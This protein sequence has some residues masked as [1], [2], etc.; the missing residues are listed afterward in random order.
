SG[1]YHISVTIDDRPTDTSPADADTD[2]SATA[3]VSDAPILA[4][5]TVN[6]T[7]TEGKDVTV[8]AEFN[9]EG[10]RAGAIDSHLSATVD[11]GD[12]TSSAGTIGAPTNEGECECN[13]MVSATRHDYDARA[14][15]FTVS[16]T[17]KDDGGSTKTS[18]LT[19]TIAD[20]ALTAGT[21]KSF[22]STAT[23]AS[24][25]VVASFSDA[26]GAQAAAAD[27]TATIK[28]GDNTTSSGT[29]TKTATGAFNVSGTHT[30]ATAGTKS[31]TVTVTDEE[32]QTA[33]MT[34]TANVGAAPV[35]L[36][37]TGQPDGNSGLPVLPAAL[38]LLGLVGVSAGLLRM[39]LA[40][41]SS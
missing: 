28:W 34:A 22:T 30:Y 14:T 15:K 21:A 8:K 36:P 9:D 17:L 31:V 24:S 29:V 12:G 32:G 2:Q 10:S 1:T 37:A 25:N 4:G 13:V 35:S 38:I 5:N 18:T 16:V 6:V 19:A 27:F 20:A 7:G 40:R 23:Q 11:W 33:T 3:T 39:R 26:A 41:R